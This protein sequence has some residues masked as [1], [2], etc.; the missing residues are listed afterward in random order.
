MNKLGQIFIKESFLVPVVAIILGL[1]TGAI[2]MLAGGFDPLLAY[3]SLLNKVFGNLYNFGETI[4][5]ITPLIFTGLSVAFAFRTGLFNIGAEG[6][7]I[8]G[9]IASVFVGITVDL[10]FYLHAPLCLLAGALAGGLWGAIAG[11]LKAF[12]GVHEV[13]TTIMLNWTAL[14]FSNYILNAFL[15]PKGEQRS[16]DIKESAYISV[17]WLSEMFDNARLHWGTLLALVAAVVFYIL[18]WKTKTGFELRAVGFNP[19][20]SEYA[21]MNVN[22]NVINAMLIGGVF[23]GLGG[24]CEVLGVFHYQAILSAMPGYGFD[25]IAVALIGGNTAVGVVL[26]AILFGVLTYGASGMNFGAGVP[27]ELIRVVIASVIFFVAA[28]GIVKYILKP[29]I[30]KKKEVL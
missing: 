26:G 28:H 20:A 1:L 19:H 17:Q 9:M 29:V 14:Y 30:S 5:Q 13:I 6:Q 7:F 12:R 27:V 16:E 3:Q 23:A 2:A 11:Y 25:G 8:M 10:P 18:L 15:V 21:G 4:R 24:A 22:K